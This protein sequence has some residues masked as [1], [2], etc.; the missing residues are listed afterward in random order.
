MSKTYH[1]LDRQTGA[2]VGGFTGSDA[3]LAINTP[4]GCDA[5]EGEATATAAPV[6]D[7]AWSARAH[8]DTLLTASDWTQLGDVVLTGPVRAAW[9]NYRKALRDLTTAPGF[10]DTVTW[11]GLPSKTSER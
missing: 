7:A 9:A 3:A 1:F 8:R 5:V 6:I 11:P 10:P 2:V 4:S